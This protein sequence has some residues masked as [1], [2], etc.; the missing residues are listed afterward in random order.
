MKRYLIAIVALL[1][2]T[3]HSAIGSEEMY[4][5]SLAQGAVMNR[6]ILSIAEM[7]SFA[8]NSF[9][10]GTARSMALAGAMTSLGGDATSMMI[11][12]AGLGMYRTGEI[13]VTPIVTI[14]KSS[15]AG[16]SSYLN[17]GR[18]TGAMSNVSAV[19]N[20]YE[21][22]NTQ[23]VS[24][25]F[26]FGYNR[27]A[28][29][30]YGYSFASMGNSS[31]I[32]NLFSRQLTD[33]SVPLDAL[34]GNDNPNWNDIPTN[35]WGAVLGYKGGLT[36]QIY[37]SNSSDPDDTDSPIWSST[38]I[39]PAATVDQYMRVESDGSIGEYD[40]SMGGN[41]SNKIYFGL[42]VGILSLDQ[43][44]DIFYGED[45]N[46]PSSFNGDRLFS[47]DYA[48]TIITKGVG[49]NVKLGLVARPI[50]ALR[51]GIAYHSPT[52]YSLDREY[53]GAMESV[54]EY[55]GETLSGYTTSPVLI[56]NQDNN[57][58]YKTNSKLMLGASYTFGDRALIS[59]DYERDWYGSMRMTQ[60]P[61]GLSTEDYNGISDIYQ[62]VNILRV[63]GEMKV[64]P[65]VALR[66]GY[67]YSSNMVSDNS[68]TAGLLDIPTTNSVNY[69]SAG[70][71]FALSKNIN[72]DITY[73]CQDNKLSDYTLFYG[74]GSISVGDGLYDSEIPSAQSAQSKS[75]STSIKQ[76]KI[77]FSMVFR[78]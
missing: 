3:V 54:A 41:I 29:L 17:N 69:Y 78:M 45:Y 21:N 74:Q 23:L 30:N 8:Q 64:T 57:W 49:V 7:G 52:K 13:A 35:L 9:T 50:E 32:A 61:S 39:S 53:Q 63:G 60:A 4:I 76:H 37:E 22:A 31:S 48:Q 27:V 28:D 24:L 71:G 67:G 70:V 19:F 1:S 15:T 75:F 25:N 68:T 40:L 73:M 10:F 2:T 20:V 77:A 66:G 12:P 72:F 51:I 44:L 58:S 56:D 55:N 47:S 42:T 33:Y 6:D 11:N 43:R 59:V 36:D 14:Q 34:Y 16:G 46:N 5:R 18:T 65:G 62:S 38:W 26:G